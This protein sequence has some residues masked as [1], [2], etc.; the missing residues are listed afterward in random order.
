MK[1]K[2]LATFLVLTLAFSALAAPP[3]PQ[4]TITVSCSACALNEHISY[5]GSGFKQ[6]I[7]VYLS[8]DG[9]TSRAIN[10]NIGSNGGFSVDFGGLLDYEKG[11]YTVTAYASSRKGATPLTSTTFTVGL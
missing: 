11:F 2:L 6:G 1:H 5:T 10:V 8:V 9:A 7:S 4:P 3:K